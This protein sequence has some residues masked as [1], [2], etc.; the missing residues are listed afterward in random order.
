MKLFASDGC[1]CVCVCVCVL[2]NY[3]VRLLL[4]GHDVDDEDASS[5]STVNDGCLLLALGAAIGA[6]AVLTLTIIAATATWL[7]C[8][9][10]SLTSRRV[11]P[12]CQFLL[13]NL[14]LICSTC[15]RS[16]CLSAYVIR[17]SKSTRPSSRKVSVQPTCLLYFTI[18]QLFGNSL[19]TQGLSSSVL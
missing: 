1:V 4:I 12:C 10:H 6:A 14:L 15:C 11:S 13:N 17:I 5:S 7:H 8:R 2:K 9:Q 16:V 19:I 3:T 18:R